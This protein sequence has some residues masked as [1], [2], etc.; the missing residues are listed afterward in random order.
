[1]DTMNL[2]V[3]RNIKQLREEKKLSM[4][5]LAKLSGV[6][7]SMLAQV[8]RGEGNPTLSTL[9]K[10]SNGMK[11][12]FNALTI[13]P[14]APY[15][16]VRTADIQPILEDNGNVKNYCLFPDDENRKF[17]VYYMELLPGSQWQS[18]P[19]LRGTTE[20]VTIFTGTLEITTDHKR[21]VIQDGE[22][23]R[24]RGD[25]PHAYCNPSDK[26]TVLLMILYNP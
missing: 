2:I 1:M 18:E 20:F 11:V 26:S 22:S 10:L 8:E 25:N 7:K 3:A 23:V 17:S 4:D 16:I 19:H 24:F 13:S 14:K 21:I 9:W 15:E 12:P 5:E 6:S